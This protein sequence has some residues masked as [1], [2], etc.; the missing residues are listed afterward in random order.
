MAVAWKILNIEYIVSES[1][2]TNVAK[3]VHWYASDVGDLNNWGNS[4]GNTQLEISGLDAS[5]FTS[6]SSLTEAQVLGWV[7]AALGDDEVGRIE[8][9]IGATIGM[10]TMTERQV[11]LPSW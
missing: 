1:G 7:K 6:W 8:A 3:N 11:G 4:W 10:G 9:F 5:S 2:L